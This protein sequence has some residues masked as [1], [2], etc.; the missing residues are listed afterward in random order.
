LFDIL[1]DDGEW[2]VSTYATLCT[3]PMEFSDIENDRLWQQE[4][5]GI[6]PSQTCP[7]SG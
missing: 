1:L 3:G 7:V 6:K 2:G 5:E 4:Q